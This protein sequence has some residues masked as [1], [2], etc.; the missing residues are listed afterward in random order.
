[1]TGWK[2]LDVNSI[3]DEAALS[4]RES[5]NDSSGIDKL[6]VLQHKKIVELE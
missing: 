4:D 2:S 6:V 5:R 1:L 3:N